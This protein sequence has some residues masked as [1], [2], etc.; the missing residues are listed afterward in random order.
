[1][2]DVAAA[3]LSQLLLGGVFECAGTEQSP[4]I[5]R[6]GPATPT[7]YPNCDCSTS[8]P[9]LNAADFTCFLTRFASADPYANC[10]GSTIPPTLNIADFSCFLNAFTSGCP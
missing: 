2:G 8:P 10:D 1:M 3:E 9:I 4:A 5:A 7:C 6:L